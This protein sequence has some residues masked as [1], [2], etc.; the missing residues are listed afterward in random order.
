V[1]EIYCPI[2]EKF[3]PALNKDAVESGDDLCWIF[4][5]DSGLIHT[6]DDIEA[7]DKGIH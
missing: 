1:S 2:C 6:N 3:I 7:L 4:I 5:H